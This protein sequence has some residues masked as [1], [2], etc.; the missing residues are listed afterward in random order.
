MPMKSMSTKREAERAATT[1]S[2][3]DN[4]YD[5]RSKNNIN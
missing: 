1:F 2:V 3:D 4:V 5:K